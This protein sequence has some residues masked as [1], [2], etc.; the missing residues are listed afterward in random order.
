MSVTSTIE[1]ATR[2]ACCDQQSQLRQTRH[3]ADLWRDSTAEVCETP[4]V[5]AGGECGRWIRQRAAHA[6]S[7][8]DIAETNHDHRN[9][10]INKGYDNDKQVNK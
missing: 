2:N 1:N 3:L 4:Q 5:A 10:E 6:R 9:V 7:S 8:A